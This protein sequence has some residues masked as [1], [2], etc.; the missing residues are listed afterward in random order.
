MRG[1]G[2][3]AKETAAWMVRS[4]ETIVETFLV[5][6]VVVAWVYRQILFWLKRFFVTRVQWPP[7]PCG[8]C[9]CFPQIST[10]T[11]PVFD[12]DNQPAFSWIYIGVLSLGGFAFG[13]GSV[14]QAGNVNGGAVHG[15]R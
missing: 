11:T 14:T 5:V 8:V 1:G 7:A 6:V 12:T 9:T 2:G 4:G 15:A 10:N 3:Q 13:C